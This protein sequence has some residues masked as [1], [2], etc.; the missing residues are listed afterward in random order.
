MANSGMR[1]PRMMSVAGSRY[2]DRDPVDSRTSRA[3]RT[4]AGIAMS[5]S[6]EIARVLGA[7]WARESECQR[8]I[9]G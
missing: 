3:I 1:M 4:N 9:S 2:D 5:N 7:E 8:P 6:V